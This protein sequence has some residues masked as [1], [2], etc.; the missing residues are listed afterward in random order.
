MKKEDNHFHCLE[1]SIEMFFQ[2][3]SQLVARS[4]TTW[5]NSRL[6]TPLRCP[7]PFTD[8]YWVTRRSLITHCTDSCGK[9]SGSSSSQPLNFKKKQKKPRTSGFTQLFKS[10]TAIDMKSLC[11]LKTAASWPNPRRLRKGPHL[12]YPFHPPAQPS[13]LNF[14]FE[15]LR[16]QAVTRLSG[17]RTLGNYVVLARSSGRRE[18]ALVLKI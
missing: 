16:L 7:S 1:F 3:S 13:L 17:L 5:A 2:M 10:D 6:C 12:R 18:G 11:F 14:S 9:E 15:T 8:V 4:S